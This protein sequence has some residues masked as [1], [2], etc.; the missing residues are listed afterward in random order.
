MFDQDS[1]KRELKELQPI[2]KLIYLKL[3][4]RPKHTY[5][6]SKTLFIE[7]YI[8]IVIKFFSCIRFISFFSR[9]IDSWTIYF[10]YVLL[11]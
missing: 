4:L 7:C 5:D 3:N 8:P 11:L 9:L 2:N 6:S 10:A 1:K